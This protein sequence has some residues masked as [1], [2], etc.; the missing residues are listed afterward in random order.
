M[1]LVSACSRP[2]EDY[3]GDRLVVQRA[4]IG[5]EVDDP[6]VG[7]DAG[8]ICEDDA[9]RAIDQQQQQQQQQVVVCLDRQGASREAP[10]Y[11]YVSID[12]DGTEIV[13]SVVVTPWLGRW[14]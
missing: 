3:Q 8:G 14:S 11:R 5:L 1:V 6:M 9:Q 4:F 7:Q 13:K 10:S 12:V 2:R